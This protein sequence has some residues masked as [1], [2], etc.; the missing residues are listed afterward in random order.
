MHA[1][2]IL[3]NSDLRSALLKSW[4]LKIFVFSVIMFCISLLWLYYSIYILLQ[5]GCFVIWFTGEKNVKFQIIH[6]IAEVLIQQFRN[7]CLILE[8]QLEMS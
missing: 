5:N 2:Q 3:S 4:L 1:K 8:V 7:R 6:D